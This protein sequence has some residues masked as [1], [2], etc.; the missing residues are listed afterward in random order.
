MHD[1]TVMTTK[2]IQF[3]SKT[4]SN[5]GTLCSSSQELWICAL[6]QNFHWREKR[7][8]CV[9]H[10]V[11][12]GSEILLTEQPFDVWPC[13]TRG[14]FTQWIMSKLARLFRLS[15]QNART[16]RKQDV[17]RAEM[18]AENSFSHSQYKDQQG[19]S[20]SNILARAK[21][22]KTSTEVSISQI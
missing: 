2:Q 22:N 18:S 12:C 21:R 14:T 15:S 10:N 8:K 17:Y 5:N 7:L 6:L 13:V 11:K 1:V 20:S 19:Y 4:T 16:T 9:F 3:N